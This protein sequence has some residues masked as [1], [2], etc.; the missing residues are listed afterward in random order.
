M[1][2]VLLILELFLPGNERPIHG[3]IEMPGIV[4][5]QHRAAQF[6][7]TFAKENPEGGQ[8]MAGCVVKIPPKRDA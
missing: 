1:K 5:C 2:T 3:E 4:E 7:D 6:I 8:A